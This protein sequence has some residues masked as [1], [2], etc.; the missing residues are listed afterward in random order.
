MS[1]GETARQWSDGLARV[2]VATDQL[3]RDMDAM[4][5]YTAPQPRVLGSLYDDLMSAEAQYHAVPIYRRRWRRPS[6]FQRPSWPADH[7][8][9]VHARLRQVLGR[10]RY[11]LLVVAHRPVRS[12]GRRRIMGM[13]DRSRR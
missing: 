3:G 6:S 2:F 7:A 12:H 9:A 8:E 1:D 13:L 10:R 4:T 5:I 11:L